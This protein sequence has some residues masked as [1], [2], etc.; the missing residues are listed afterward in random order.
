MRSGALLIEFNHAPG[1]S[2][3]KHPSLLSVLCSTSSLLL[4]SVC[5]FFAVTRVPGSRLLELKEPALN[6]E[7]AFRRLA[8]LC[9][10][11]RCMCVKNSLAHNCLI[12][13]LY[14]IKIGVMISNEI[15]M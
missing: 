5:F 8:V 6:S 1:V 14:T 11:T 12:A 3:G 7:V 9:M 10:C 4:A 15:S 13:T 2:K